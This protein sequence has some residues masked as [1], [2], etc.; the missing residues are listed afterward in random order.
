MS[1]TEISATLLESLT[2]ERNVVRSR[3][4]VLGTQ[5]SRVI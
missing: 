4:L 3:M 1:Y 2:D 5:Q